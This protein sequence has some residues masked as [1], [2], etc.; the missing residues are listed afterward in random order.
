M[1]IGTPTKRVKIRMIVEYD[2]EVPA[3]WDKRQIEFHRNDSSWCASNAI[4][5]LEAL[6]GENHCICQ[7][8]TFECIGDEG[9]NA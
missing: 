8:T 6:D 2:V 1:T 3:H 4:E 5:E 7:Y 9:I